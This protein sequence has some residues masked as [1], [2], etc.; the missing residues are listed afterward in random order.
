MT[1]A[2][3]H[4]AR[5][6]EALRSDPENYVAFPAPAGPMGRGFMPVILGL[7]IPNTA[8]N[9]EGAMD[10]IRHLVKPET[11]GITLREVAFF[12]VSA[13]EVPADVDAA[14]QMQLDAVSAQANSEDALL[15]QLPVGLGDQGGAYSDVFKN[16]F[17]AI[18]IDGGDPAT[19]L[20]AFAPALQETLDLSGAACWAPDPASDGV[21]QVGNTIGG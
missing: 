2:W 13:G 4:T 11:Q 1:V 21:C 5:L 18:I 17:K 12:P 15:A 7:A 19:V 10:L 8:P 6:I 9:P 16:A 3:D 14:V 20:P